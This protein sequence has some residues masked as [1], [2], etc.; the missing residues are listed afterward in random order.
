MKLEELQE[1]WN[2]FG[3]TDP[4][5]GIL[6]W[7]DKTENRWQVDA[8]FETGVE[9][10]DAVLA[11][12]AGLG[13]EPKFGAALD[14]G[15]GVGRLSQALARRFELVCGVDI[16]PA[17]I[18]LAQQYN[19]FGERCQYHLNETDD[20]RLFESQSF[21]FIYSNITLQHMPPRYASAYIAEFLRILAP[22]G[23]LIFQIPS[24]PKSGLRRLA[25]PLRPTFLWRT[26]QKWRYGDQPVMDMYGIP[27]AQVL[28]LL[29][30]HGGQL[31]DVQPDDSADA[32]WISYRYCVTKHA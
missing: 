18:E 30:T 29:K 10:I 3:E 16:S 21:D 2:K 15:C 25:Q 11:Y 32:A 14:F 1:N 26:Y 12:A 4:L 7:P 20:L 23:A 13:L 5:W 31:V 22:G 19:Q 24:T 17:M 8:F 27:R 9:E 28:H 6:A